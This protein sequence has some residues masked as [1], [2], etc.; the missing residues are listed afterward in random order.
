MCG[1]DEKY[2]TNMEGGAKAPGRELLEEA[3][4]VA[5]IDFQSCIVLPQDQPM[6]PPQKRAFDAFTAALHDWRFAAAIDAAYFLETMQRPKKPK[7][8]GRTRKS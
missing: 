4:R 5:G 1:V 8:G 3:A 2:Y 6:N 7:H